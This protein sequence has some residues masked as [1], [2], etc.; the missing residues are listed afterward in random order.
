MTTSLI[1]VIIPTYNR[2]ADILRAVNSVLTQTYAFY[3]II[4]IDD[5]S[6]D[7][8][9]SIIKSINDRRIRY[10]RSDRNNGVAAARNIGIKNATGELIAFLDSDDEWS[11][12]MLDTAITCLDRMEADFVFTNGIIVNLNKKIHSSTKMLQLNISSKKQI[13]TL[14]F[15]GNFIATQGVLFKKRILNIS[16]YFDESFKS[17]SDYDLWLRLIP[18][19]KIAYID[20]PLFW[21]HF[22]EGSIT[23]NV[24]NR[25]KYYS[26]CFKKNY[27]I[28]S[29]ICGPIELIMIR[30]KFYS[31]FLNMIAWDLDKR[32]H[33]PAKAILLYLIAF[34]LSPNLAILQCFHGHPKNE[35]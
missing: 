10:L 33:E 35:N 29:N 26:L 21:L 27:K 13:A 5:G 6:T 4:I 2:E 22:S 24:K 9:E 3:E 14:L 16:G 32:N 11:A 1:S 25:L 19:I 18:F 34:V 23:Y 17:A 12:G 30:L 7:N 20:M 28:I 8:T 31:N 15:K